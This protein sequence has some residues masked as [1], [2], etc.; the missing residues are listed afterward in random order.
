MSAHLRGHVRA[1][2]DRALPPTMLQSFDRHLV[3]CAMCR[4]LADQER[5]IVSALR[6][7][8]GVPQGL[9][10]SL[11]GLAA[12]SLAQPSQVPSVPRPP[13]GHR[14][15][16]TTAAPPPFPAR[17]PIVAPSSPALHRSPIRAA[18]FAS[19]AAGASVAAAWGLAVSPLP[20]GGVARLPDARVPSGLQSVAPASLAP[21]FVGPSPTGVMT[22]SQAWYTARPARS[23]SATTT[24]V[25]FGLVNS[26][27]SSP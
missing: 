19:L 1:Y 17:V 20:S 8:T 15:P 27:E 14:M 24:P 22:P 6:A 13:L 21:A 16:F 5:R 9:R 2:V 3:C 10:S 18:V 4:A 12:A 11:M 23:L 25:R 7:E 26:A